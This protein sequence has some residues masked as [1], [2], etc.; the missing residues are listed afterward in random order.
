MI[1]HHEQHERA[2]GADQAA[3]GEV[4]QLSPAGNSWGVRRRP[5]HTKSPCVALPVGFAGNGEH[6]SCV[7]G[8]DA[9]LIYLNVGKVVPFPGKRSNGAARVYRHGFLAAHGNNHRGWR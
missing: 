7:K 6:C 2:R 1:L 3:T 9:A 8:G 4:I 5:Q